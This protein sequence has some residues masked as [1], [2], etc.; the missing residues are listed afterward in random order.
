MSWYMRGGVSVNDLMFLYTAE[1]RFIIYGIIK[2]NLELT[3]TAQ[4][5]LI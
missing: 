2:D 4:M 1:D 5:P 3:K